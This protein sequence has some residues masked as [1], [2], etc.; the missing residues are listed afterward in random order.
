M[1]IITLTAFLISVSLA[2]FIHK[3]HSYLNKEIIEKRHL[4][5]RLR[6][7]ENELKLQKKAISEARTV[8]HDLK[9]HLIAMGYLV[10][11]GNNKKYAEYTQELMGKLTVPITQGFTQLPCIDAVIYAKKQDAENKGIDFSCLCSGIFN[12][13]AEYSDITILLG[14]L[15]DHASEHCRTE[16]GFI[17]LSLAANRDNIAVT[18]KFSQ[19]SKGTYGSRYLKTAVGQINKMGG[20]INTIKEADSCTVVAVIPTS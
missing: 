18:L 5:Y 13:F 8:R 9:N 4:E 19:C 7:A 2:L 12:P 15:L 11:K 10:S 6:F 16:N 3:Q 17:N 14:N 1:I 20:L